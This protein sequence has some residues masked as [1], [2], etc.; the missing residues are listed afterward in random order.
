[1]I[2]MHCIRMLLDSR[3]LRLHEFINSLVIS[4]SQKVSLPFMCMALDVVLGLLTVLD[5]KQNMFRIPTS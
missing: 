2:T 3:I 4:V 5:A 1:M